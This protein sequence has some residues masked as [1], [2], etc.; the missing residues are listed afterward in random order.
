[1]P[2]PQSHGWIINIGDVE[3]THTG[4]HHPAYAASKHGM[5][6]WAQVGLQPATAAR[7]KGRAGQSA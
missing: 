5:R 3:A 4:P 7:G 6:G 2:P 1:M